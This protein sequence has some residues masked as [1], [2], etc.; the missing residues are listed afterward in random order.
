MCQ[1][2][3]VYKSFD[4]TTNKVNC[5]C[6]NKNTNENNKKKIKNEINNLFSNSNL[7]VLK[8]F[9]LNKNFKSLLKNYGN[10]IF[11]ICEIGEIFFAIYVLFKGYFP[12]IKKLKKIQSNIYYRKNNSNIKI[13]KNPPKKKIKFLNDSSNSS[14]DYLDKN[15]LKTNSK[16]VIYKKIGLIEEKSSNKFIMNKEKNNFTQKKYSNEEINDL[17]YEESLLID[18]RNFLL[19]YYNFLQYS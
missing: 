10:Y 4:R 17:N 9:Y 11:L 13:T 16:I 18:H 19:I 12:L 8:C 1:E 3:C 14:V 2:G 7:K 5:N 6:N 15:I